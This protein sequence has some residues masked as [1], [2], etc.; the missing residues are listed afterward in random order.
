MA[1]LLDLLT[2]NTPDC[3]LRLTFHA[4]SC[5]ILDPGVCLDLR[6]DANLPLETYELEGSLEI[7]PLESKV[8]LNSCFNCFLC[9]WREY[10]RDRAGEVELEASIGL[11]SWSNSWERFYIWEV[12]DNDKNTITIKPVSL[13]YPQKTLPLLPP[14]ISTL[15]QP[16]CVS[17]QSLL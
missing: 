17:R 5:D 13:A 12:Q 6:F 3:L 8:L 10:S 7:F 11:G 2:S 15:H 1:P 4:L 16:T 14:P 9:C